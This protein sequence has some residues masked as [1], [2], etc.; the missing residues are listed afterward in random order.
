MT[1][2]GGDIIIVSAKLQKSRYVDESPKN[3]NAPKT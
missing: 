1:P 3:L 2:A